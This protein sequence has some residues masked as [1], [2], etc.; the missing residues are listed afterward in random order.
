MTTASTTAIPAEQH[1][2][3]NR[4]APTTLRT[5]RTRPTLRLELQ[6]VLQRGGVVP[7]VVMEKVLANRVEKVAPKERV[8]KLTKKTRKAIQ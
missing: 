5:R 3:K 2:T 8:E 7:V 4:I 6:K 1:L